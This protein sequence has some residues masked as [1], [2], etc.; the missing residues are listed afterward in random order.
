MKKVFTWIL[1]VGLIAGGI[2]GFLWWRNNQ[3]AQAQSQ[4]VLRTGQVT[5]GDLNVTVVASGNVAVKNK[6]DLRFE[7]AGIVSRINVKVN[8]RVQA[9][10]ELASLSTTD[11]E[12]AV[13]QAEIALEQAKLNRDILAK[14]AAEADLEL[15]KLNVQSAA[16]ALEAARLGKQ[17]AQVDADAMIV[18]AQRAREN[19]FKD[20][21]A[22]EGTPE[23][24]SARKK[25]EN[26]EE[27]ERIA[28]LNAEVTVKQA[29]AQWLTAYSRYQQAVESLHKLEQGPDEQQLRQAELQIEQAQLN[30]EKAQ[31]QLADA[32]LTA[33]FA[34]LITAVN[35]Q[36]GLQALPGVAAFTLVDDSQFYVDVT[37]DE[38]DIGKIRIGQTAEITLDA[39]PKETLPGEVE[40]IAPGA[41]NVGGI[42][43]YRLRVR[44]S[45]P[46]EGTEGKNVVIIR[47]GMTASVLIRTDV[48]ENVLLVPNWAVRTDQSSGETVLYCYVLRADGLPE[49]RD[50]TRGRYNDTLTEVLSGLQEGETVALIA[51]ERTLLDL[52]TFGQ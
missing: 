27:Q 44:L 36:E 42:V 25:Y 19:A 41:L 13:Q 6:L 45:P 52:S 9:G 30:L 33:P 14:P 21:R 1:I 10:E 28:R 26:A 40:S 48:I 24:E 39:Y 37:V 32:R 3:A 50:I 8:Q 51:E 29:Q 49:R 46:L 12:H 17:T 7:T 35:V 31:A 22:R 34:G 11:L 23:E 5:R 43:S 38:I 4:S 47:D 20:Y 2:A 18:Q 15:A 16:Q